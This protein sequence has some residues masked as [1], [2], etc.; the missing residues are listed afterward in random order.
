[1]NLPT[2]QLKSEEDLKAFEFT[3][4]G[5]KG[6]IEK[7]IVFQKTNTPN[8]FNLAFGDKTRDGKLDDKTIS[9]NGDAEKVLTTVISAVYAFFDKNPN[10]FLYVTG[11]TKSRT[12]LY[13]IGITRFYDE[14]TEDFYL[15]G[16]IGNE[17]H[18]FEIG[19]EYEGFLAQRKFY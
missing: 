8:L 15:Y 7:L 16:K 10:C 13:R 19:K 4:E 3:S 12:R 6:N 18:P 14:M 5:L 9:N 11:S 1:M 2:Y 17:F